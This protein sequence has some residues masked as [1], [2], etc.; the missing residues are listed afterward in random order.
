MPKI[1]APL[2]NT[3]IK[4]TKAKDKI[5]F[6]SDGDGLL[7][8]V[9]PNGK[10]TFVYEFTSPVTKKRRRM[11]LGE[12]GVLSLQEAREKRNEVKKINFSG[13]DALDALK[14]P[15]LTF[16]NIFKEWIKTKKNKITQKRIFWIERRFEILFLPKLAKIDIKQIS[17]KDIINA[18]NP[19]IIDDKL[20]SAKKLLSVLNI[21]WKYAVLHEYAEHNIIA[22]IDKRTLLGNIK[23]KHFAFLKN[24]AQI[25]NLLLNIKEYS[26]DE[27]VK[28]CALFQFY[29]A[30]RGANARFAK[31]DE[32]DFKNKVWQIPA[33]KTKTNRPHEVF[34]SKSI[35]ELLSNYKDKC[36]F[37]SDFLFP[38]LR[39]NTRPISD[40]TVRAMLR[41]LGYSNDD[42]TPHGF[43]ATFST[44]CHERRDEHGQSSD[45]IELCL[46]HIEKNKIKDAYNHAKNLK[47]RTILMQW[48]SDYLDSLN[49]I[50]PTYNH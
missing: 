38:S 18:L 8:E 47:Q 5:Y 9:K 43:R 48:W 13:I 15:D 30:V 34:L 25:K 7:L 22:D 29:T 32:I 10:K 14:R 16:E 3:Q 23:T 33:Q 46:A 21:F 41:N 45:I 49:E 4:N 19:L 40:N 17:R 36:N 2:T 26:G 28:T 39:S 1:T 44:I 6:I 27:R 50:C 35:I 37:K 11:T 31:W 24:D 42:I 20:E 12:F